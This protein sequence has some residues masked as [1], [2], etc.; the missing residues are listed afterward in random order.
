MVTVAAKNQGFVGRIVLSIEELE[1]VHRFVVGMMR[2]SEDED[3]H[4]AIY[5]ALEAAGIPSETFQVV[6]VILAEILDASS[7]TRNR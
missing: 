7:M 2:S 6:Y 4:A 1:A 3:K 5:D